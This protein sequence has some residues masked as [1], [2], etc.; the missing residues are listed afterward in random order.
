MSELTLRISLSKQWLKIHILVFTQWS[1]YSSSFPKKWIV[2]ITFAMFKRFQ[3]ITWSKIQYWNTQWS[4]C[5]DLFAQ[6]FYAFVLSAALVLDFYL[7]LM[8]FHTWNILCSLCGF[9]ITLLPNLNIAQPFL[10]KHSTV[11]SLGL[12]NCFFS[13]FLYSWTVTWTL[14]IKVCFTSRGWNEIKM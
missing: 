3:P 10:V 5:A 13:F 9:S 4:Y 1:T 7:A 14:L 8:R 2:S 12:G 6:R 11:F